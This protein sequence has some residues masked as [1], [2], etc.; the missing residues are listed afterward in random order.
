RADRDD[1]PVGSSGLVA[2]LSEALPRTRLV[3]YKGHVEVPFLVASLRRT[4]HEIRFDSAE[5]VTS[6]CALIMDYTTSL[7]YIGM[8]A[9]RPTGF[10]ETLA[11]YGVTCPRPSDAMKRAE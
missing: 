5:R 1:A 10:A 6:L 4:N 7:S 3:S 9:Q 2:P 11:F 8:S